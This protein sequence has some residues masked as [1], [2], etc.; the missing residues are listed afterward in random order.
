MVLGPAPAHTYPIKC[1]N[2]K[3]LTPLPGNLPPTR[4]LSVVPDLAGFAIEPRLILCR[5]EMNSA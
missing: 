5:L 3:P 1:W 4:E 2:V